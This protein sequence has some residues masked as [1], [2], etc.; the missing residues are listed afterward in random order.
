MQIR[1]KEFA[2]SF[3]GQISWPS[4]C[5]PLFTTRIAEDLV[6]TTRVQKLRSRTRNQTRIR[7]QSCTRSKTH[8]GS[9]SR[10]GSQTRARRPRRG[11]GGGVAPHFFL[12]I[13]LKSY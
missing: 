13:I 8:T 7:N 3:P 11:G 2:K 9:Q 12:K 6:V 1:D 5:L 10:A 4:F